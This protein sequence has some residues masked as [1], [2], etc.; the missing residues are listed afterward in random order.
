[1][2]RAFGSIRGAEDLLE[3]DLAPEESIHRQPDRGLGAATDLLEPCVLTGSLVGDVVLVS[4]GT[5]LRRVHSVPS[6]GGPGSC[7]CPSRARGRRGCPGAVR[8]ARR[9][10]S[11]AAP[12]PG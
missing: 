3:R 1:G 2:V 11:G 4:A 12:P 6:S 10:R 9:A 5:D 8:A 7:A